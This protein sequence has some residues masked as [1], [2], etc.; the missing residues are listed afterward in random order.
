[1]VFQVTEDSQSLINIQEC[2]M[3]ANIRIFDY[4]H[5]VQFKVCAIIMLNATSLIQPPKTTHTH[6][7]I[8]CCI[9]HTKMPS[10]KNTTQAVF[11]IASIH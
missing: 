1:M 6:T 3:I 8:M 9:F 4:S 10:R 11:P 2:V 7:H 5:D